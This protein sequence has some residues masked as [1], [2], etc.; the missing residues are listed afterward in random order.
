MDIAFGKSSYTNGILMHGTARLAN[1]GNING[2]SLFVNSTPNNSFGD[3]LELTYTPED[4][5]LLIKGSIGEPTHLYNGDNVNFYLSDAYTAVKLGIISNTTEIISNKLKEGVSIL[6]ITGTVKED[7]NEDLT[8]QTKTSDIESSDDTKI[9]L[10]ATIPT[11]QEGIKYIAQEGNS[12]VKTTIDKSKIVTHENITADKIATGNTILGIVGTYTGG[13]EE[14]ESQITQLQEEKESLQ[15]Q[16]TQLT[17]DKES[18]SQQVTQLTADKSNLEQQVE[19]LTN[20]NTQLTNDKEELEGQVETLTN[21]NN[22][23]NES[24]E[25]YESQINAINQTA[26]NILGHD[27]NDDN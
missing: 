8:G 1:D 2:Y 9:T 3:C 23:L 26:I 14:L 27:A 19:T 25:N 24:I 21:T 11:T 5:L 20:T 13:V 18:L 4:H 6:G 15:S 22:Q 16:V 7:L 12:E 17:S 10:K